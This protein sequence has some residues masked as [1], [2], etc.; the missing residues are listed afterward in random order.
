MKKGKQTKNVK[1]LGKLIS[2]VCEWGYVFFCETKIQ[3]KQYK[4]G[5]TKKIFLIPIS[6]PDA[7]N[8]LK[9][10][11]FPQKSAHFPPLQ[12]KCKKNCNSHPARVE[13]FLE[14]NGGEEWF[15]NHKEH[16]VKTKFHKEINNEEWWMKNEEWRIEHTSTRA[17]EHMST[18]AHEHY[19][20]V[21]P[22]INSLIT[23]P[24]LMIQCKITGLFQSQILYFFLS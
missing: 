5:D 12:K 3:K 4:N 21:C 1:S 17:H 18:R 9:F 20:M 14:G 2:L 10:A 16:K 11:F 13:L 22:K 23:N 15:F 6:A 8:T 19:G 24:G 7:K